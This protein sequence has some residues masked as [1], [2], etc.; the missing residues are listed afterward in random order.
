VRIHK[1]LRRSA[2]GS[3]LSGCDSGGQE[4]TPEKRTNE[5]GFPKAGRWPEGERQESAPEEEYDQES[6]QAERRQA[7]EEPHRRQKQGDCSKED[8]QEKRP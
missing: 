6:S 1:D 4:S 8:R 3:A 7:V 5:S 2:H